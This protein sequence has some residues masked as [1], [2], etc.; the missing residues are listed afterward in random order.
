M[1]L[2]IDDEIIYKGKPDY[3]AWLK[4]VL[5]FYERKKKEQ[6]LEDSLFHLRPDFKDLVLKYLE[7]ARV[8]IADSSEMEDII[9][10]RDKNYGEEDEVRLCIEGI[11]KVL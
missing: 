2:S 11:K 8:L 10:Q 5:D 9:Y 1:D 3:D 4:A 6:E 7:A